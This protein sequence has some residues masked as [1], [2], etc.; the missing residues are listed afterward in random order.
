MTIPRTPVDTGGRVRRI[1]VAYDG[2]E[3]SARAVRFAL[4]VS[5]GEGVEVWIVHATDPPRTVAEPR[6]D[7]EQGSESD[8][9]EQSLRAIQS[10]VNPAGNRVHVWIRE[11]KA[12][13]VIL[14]AATEVDADMTVVGTR[15]LRGAGKI[16][17]GSVSSEVLAHSGRPVTVVP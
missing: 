12:A 8:A 9:I 7:E 2:S 4:G 1:V 6:T 3:S 14:S 11:G 17:L 13:G 5:M 10:A 16:L 15:G